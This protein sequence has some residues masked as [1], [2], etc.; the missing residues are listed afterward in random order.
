MANHPMDKC[1]LTGLPMELL[2]ERTLCIRPHPI[3]FDQL[4][5]MTGNIQ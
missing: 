5:N 2:I 1:A 3:I 4:P